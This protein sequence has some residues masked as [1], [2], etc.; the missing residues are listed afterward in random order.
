MAF[1][2]NCVLLVLEKLSPRH[3]FILADLLDLLDNKHVSRLLMARFGDIGAITALENVIQWNID[4][5]DFVKLI[6]HESGMTYDDVKRTNILA[7]ACQNGSP[8]IILW[9]ISKFHLR[10][11]DAWACHALANSVSHLE[12]VQALLQHYGPSVWTKGR[13]IMKNA[14]SHKNQNVM[15]FIKNTFPQKF[16]KHADFALNV[17]IQKGHISM[18]Q[19]LINNGNAKFCKNNLCFDFVVAFSNGCLPMLQWLVENDHFQKTH[20]DYMIDQFNELRTTNCNENLHCSQWLFHTFGHSFINYENDLKI[21]GTKGNMPFIQWASEPLCKSEHQ[22]WI[23]HV[24]FGALE[25][26]H[27]EICEWCLERCVMDNMFCY[28]LRVTDYALYSANIKVFEW[29]LKHGLLY[30]NP[31]VCIMRCLQHRPNLNHKGDITPFLVHVIDRLGLWE[32]VAHDFRFVNAP[33]SFVTVLSK[34]VNLV[35]NAYESYKFIDLKK[36]PRVLEWLIKAYPDWGVPVLRILNCTSHSEHDLGFLIPKCHTMTE[37]LALAKECVYGGHLPS[38]KKLVG[39]VNK[40]KKKLFKLAMY[41]K[42]DHVVEWLLSNTRIAKNSEVLVSA[43]KKAIMS[44]DFHIALTLRNS[45]TC[46]LA[47]ERC[48]EFLHARQSQKVIAFTKLIQ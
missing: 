42:H 34:R 10:L 1:N 2:Y 24:F 39:V 19:M 31:T 17:A 46:P 40:G 13:E 43:F 12:N 32:S 21:L 15:E 41:R 8:D 35:L 16:L 23:V 38:L 33:V 26:G 37:K 20:F 4:R 29:I 30:S 3:A 7:Y 5:L 28:K 47:W 27:L 25:G 44:R 45:I 11:H 6:V 18:A 36:N 9:L 22:D 14:A 48:L